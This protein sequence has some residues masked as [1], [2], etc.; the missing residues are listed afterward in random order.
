MHNPT[1]RVLDIMLYISEYE[2]LGLSDISEGT[3][4]PKSTISPIL[5]TLVEMK[6]L[7]CDPSGR[8][9]IGKNAF[10][11]GSVFL[12]SFSA[13]DVIRQYMA[14]IVNECNEICHL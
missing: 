14:Q 8:F 5:K 7:H 6:F 4:I 13:T 1:K 10:K 9:Y 12:R 11:V 2:G 3:Q